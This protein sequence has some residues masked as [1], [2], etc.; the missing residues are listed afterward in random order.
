MD[1][2]FL[3]VDTTWAQQASELGVAGLVLFAFGLFVWALLNNWLITKGRYLDREEHWA[4]IVAEKDAAI[5]ER[6]GI[7]REQTALIS[8]MQTHSEHQDADLKRQYGEMVN[9]VQ[10]V[11]LSSFSRSMGGGENS[12]PQR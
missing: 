10:Q 3:Q 9:L 6:D 8:R 5:T 7:I 12:G 1:P 11:T 4:T 2:M